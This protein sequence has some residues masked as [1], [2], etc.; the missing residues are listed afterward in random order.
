M[1]E[2]LIVP[3]SYF[4]ETCLNMFD[5]QE[6][7]SYAE[8][9]RMGADAVQTSGSSAETDAAVGWNWSRRQA[10]AHRAAVAA[11][12]MCYVMMS[13]EPGCGSGDLEP[14]Y[15]HMSGEEAVAA[16][17]EVGVVDDDSD[18]TVQPGGDTVKVGARC[19]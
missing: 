11:D 6:H 5:T 8:R 9:T 12:S 14:R 7:C 13:A 3:Y 16:D 10:G 2:A 15:V 17:L 18:Q 19:Y 1:P 4:L